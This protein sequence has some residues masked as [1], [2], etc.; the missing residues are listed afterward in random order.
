M[1]SKVKVK[2]SNTLTLLP[3]KPKTINQQKIFDYF[4][5]GKHLFIHGFAGTGKTMISLYLALEAVLEDEFYDKIILVRSAVPSRTQGYL[6]GTEEEKNEIFELPFIGICN[7]L[8]SKSN[9]YKELKFKEKIKFISTSYLRG[10]TIDN[11]VII[12]DE[13]QN[14]TME[15]IDT[16]I[17]RTGKD[18]RLIILGDEKQGDLKNTREISCIN[19]L[20]KIIDRMKSFVKVE[21]EIQ[22]ICRNDIVKEW[23]IASSY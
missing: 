14:M 15:E 8:F 17:T 21:M 13:V 4:D 2:E 18:C 19:N 9:S 20:H 11:A 3:I 23:L 10:I 7:E 1:V 22:D 6:P 5:K 16:V 12:I